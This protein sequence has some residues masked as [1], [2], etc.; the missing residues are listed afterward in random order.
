MS[1]ATQGEIE[2]V[3]V[4][5]T[6]CDYTGETCDVYFTGT[7]NPE[8]QILN[9]SVTKK[10]SDQTRTDGFRVKLTDD[11]IYNIE[12]YKIVSNGGCTNFL[13]LENIDNTSGNKS[14]HRIVILNTEKSVV[15]DGDCTDNIGK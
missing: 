7:Y 6:G 12:E 2:I 15:K 1:E 9:G 14:V 10:Y 13:D 4:Q 8:T 3:P 5:T 11:N